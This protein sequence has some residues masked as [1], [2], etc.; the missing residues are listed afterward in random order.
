MVYGKIYRGSSVEFSTIDISVEE[1]STHNHTKNDWQE[2]TWMDWAEQERYCVHG[3]ISF[4]LKGSVTFPPNPSEIQA[5]LDKEVLRCEK[6]EKKLH[7]SHQKIKKLIG[8]L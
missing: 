4:A 2:V 6:L 3:S 7:K 5:K 8:K 1:W